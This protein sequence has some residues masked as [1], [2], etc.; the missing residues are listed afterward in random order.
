MTDRGCVCL[1]PLCH[2]FSKGSRIIVV[3]VVA[4]TAVEMSFSR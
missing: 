3:V 4:F 2:G 1:L